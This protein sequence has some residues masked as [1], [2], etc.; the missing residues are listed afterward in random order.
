MLRCTFF[1]YFISSEIW[2]CFTFTGKPIYLAVFSPFLLFFWLP[3]TACGDL[4]TRDGIRAPCSG[5]I[6]VLTTGPPQEFPIFLFF[7]LWSLFLKKK[8][9]W[10][11]IDKYIIRYLK[12]NKYTY[13]LWK[14]SPSKMLLKT[15]GMLDSMKYIIYWALNMLQAPGWSISIPYHTTHYRWEKQLREVK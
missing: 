15:D 6:R 3:H 8:I 12:Y 13:T 2:V 9:Y 11:I 4:L 14:D 10:D 1:S 7:F 5:S